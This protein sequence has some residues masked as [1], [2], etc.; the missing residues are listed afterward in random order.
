MT[1]TSLRAD[2][3]P[4]AVVAELDGRAR[5]FETPCGDG[6][7]VWRAWGSG[8]PVLLAH[9]SHGSWLHWIRNIDALAT[10]RTVWAPDL[11]GYGESA[12]PPQVDHATITA[13]MAEGMRQ[14]L[15]AALPV[16]IIGFSY[17]G[18]LAAHLAAR[19]PELVRRLVLVDTG[20]LATPMGPLALR[21]FRKLAGDARRSA[22]RDNL[23]A[24]MIHDPARIDELALHLQEI[25]SL[26]ARMNPTDLVLPD[27]LIEVL[28]KITAQLSVIWAEFD[29][30]HPEPAVQ[31]AVLRRYRPEIAFRVIAGAGHWVMY[32][33]AD[34]FNRVA[35]DLLARRLT[36]DGNG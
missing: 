27:R 22:L 5:R 17:G 3:D 9:G 12:M 14:L 20:G 34:A 16:D 31:E 1:A 25:D 32:E 35:A 13:V 8:P 15:T 21:G 2:S 10:E 19:Q 11:P 30:P 4:A 33:Q 18:L 26:R 24:L 23:H 36:P 6:A 7:M 29:Q 28:P